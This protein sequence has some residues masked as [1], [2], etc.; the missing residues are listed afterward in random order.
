ML[1]E[2]SFI[3]FLKRNKKIISIV[4]LIP[5]LIAYTYIIFKKPCHTLHKIELRTS[6]DDVSFFFDR[7][8][9]KIKEEG[10]IEFSKLVMPYMEFK[11][12]NSECTQSFIKSKKIFEELNAYIL[13]EM[14]LS[15]REIIDYTTNFK[16]QNNINELLIKFRN[17]NSQ[18]FKQM[19]IDIST[20]NFWKKIGI[21]YSVISLSDTPYFYKN[22]RI[23]FIATF[24]SLILSLLIIFTIFF[25][26]YL[27]RKL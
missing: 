5:L 14:E 26:K 15:E 4:I 23:I 22:I 2:K 25:Y 18:V 12:S 21:K 7:L 19:G 1:I 27:F 16:Q 24:G 11:G 6:S 17:D 13:N 9:V 20:Y 3:I 10:K 8:L